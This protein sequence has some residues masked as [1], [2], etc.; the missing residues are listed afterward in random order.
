MQLTERPAEYAPFLEQVRVCE[1]RVLLLDYDGTL[2]P[3]RVDRDQAFPYAGVRELLHE[4]MQEKTRLVLISGRRATDILQLGGIDPRPE[5]WGSHGLERLK[6]DGTYEAASVGDEQRLG[7]MKAAAWVRAEGL[8]RKAEFKPG[9]IAIHWRGLPART[10]EQTRQQIRAGWSALA[11]DHRLSL[12]AFDGGMEIRVPAKNKG[13]AV[14]TIL[15]ET[16]GNF[17]A[18]YLGDDET[19]EDAFRAIKGK[20]LSILVREQARPTMA[21]LWLKPP[22]ELI[23]FLNSWL[24]ACRGEA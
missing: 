12:L 5:I 10:A 23:Q 16:K 24:R 11:E 15:D 14:K 4:I 22:E 9:S 6:K 21:D 19:D 13:D 3:F 17:A 7:L 1:Q 20:G 8:E 18:A 2:A